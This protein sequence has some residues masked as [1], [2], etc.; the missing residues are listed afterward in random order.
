VKKKKKRTTDERARDVE[1]L[2]AEPE[3]GCQISRKKLLCGMPVFVIIRGPKGSVG[4]C[5][6]CWTRLI[7]IA[8]D[9][10]VDALELRRKYEPRPTL[11]RRRADKAS[12]QA[13]SEGSTSRR[14]TR[15]CCSEQADR[16]PRSTAVPR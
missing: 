2:D 10:H 4:I 11:V 7:E 15:N 9:A 14:A 1:W 5:I 8:A 13:R 3:Q 12:D 6:E 16:A